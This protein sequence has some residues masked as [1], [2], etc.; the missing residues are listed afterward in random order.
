MELKAF[1]ETKFFSF[2]SQI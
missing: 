2:Y 1:L